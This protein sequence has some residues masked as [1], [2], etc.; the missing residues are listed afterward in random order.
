MPLWEGA[1]KDKFTLKIEQNC[2]KP[3]FWPVSGVHF[4]ACPGFGQKMLE[5]IVFIFR[6]R[7]EFYGLIFPG[8]P[9][10]RTAQNLRPTDFI[11]FFRL[12]TPRARPIKLEGDDKMRGA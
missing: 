6:I 1:S 4:G 7:G 5:L 10:S 3:T 11:V 2:L 12:K 8:S 9:E